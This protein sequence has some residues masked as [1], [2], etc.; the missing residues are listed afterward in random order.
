MGKYYCYSSTSI[1]ARYN[2]HL[3]KWQLKRKTIR[4]RKRQNQVKAINEMYQ[5]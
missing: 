4:Q 1:K 3:L 2:L 5:K